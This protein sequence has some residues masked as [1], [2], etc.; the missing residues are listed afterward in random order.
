MI[1]SWTGNELTPKCARAWNAANFLKC[2]TA[3]QMVAHN[4][5]TVWEYGNSCNFMSLTGGNR[6]MS[7]FSNLRSWLLEYAAIE[8]ETLNT[9][10][11]ATSSSCVSISRIT[12]TSSTSFSSHK[13]ISQ[14]SRLI[15]AG[16]F[17][18]TYRP[19]ALM[20]RFSCSKVP[21]LLIS[22]T[23]QLDDEKTRSLGG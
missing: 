15:V 14:T 16:A 10:H 22:I 6:R 7:I 9:N 2:R 17:K 1:S 4:D 19:V 3:Y 23:E 8:L 20:L 21:M 11:S 12:R 13:V 5:R 18:Q